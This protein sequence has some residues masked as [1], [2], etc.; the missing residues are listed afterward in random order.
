MIVISASVNDAFTVTL[1][2]SHPI[3]ICQ[4]IENSCDK[5]DVDHYI[6]HTSSSTVY[7]L[8]WCFSLYAC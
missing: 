2:S 5:F 4:L 1:F 8:L 7:S 6:P 3:E